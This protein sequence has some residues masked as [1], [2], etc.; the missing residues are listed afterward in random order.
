MNLDLPSVLLIA[1]GLSM[2]AFAVAVASSI[3][4][5][6]VN[7]RQL[8]RFSFHFGLF[9]ALMPMIG[10]IMG[11]VAAEFI[12]G[13]DH[14]VAFL[15]L[16]LV[17]GKSFLGSLRHTEP[18]GDRALKGDPTRGWSLVIFSVATSIDA[19]AVGI[20][21]AAMQVT[22]WLPA[23]VIGLVTASLTLVGMLLGSRIGT[24][25]GKRIERLGGLI[26]IG[27]GAKILVSHLLES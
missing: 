12:G 10:W 9:Q 22:I 24:R 6:Q 5:G 15:L 4:M 17:G 2:D 11:S 18:E 8:F 13:W 21:L 7:R 14:W 3:A 26:L 25:F 16:G 20:A 27:I 19:L 23:A 1:V